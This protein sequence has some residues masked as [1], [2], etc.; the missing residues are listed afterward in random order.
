[1]TALLLVLALAGGCG[2]APLFERP[3]SPEAEL[4]RMQAM[5][6][7]LRALQPAP[8]AAPSVL[9][10]DDVREILAVLRELDRR[11]RRLEEHP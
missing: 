3:P 6:G 5:V 1:M 11:V 10:A 2:L 9:T 4:A 7:V 8:A